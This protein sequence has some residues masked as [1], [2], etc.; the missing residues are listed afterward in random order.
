MSI[1]YVNI[2]KGGEME[3]S[4]PYHT[5]EEAILCVEALAYKLNEVGIACNKINNTTWESKRRVIRVEDNGNL[6]LYVKDLWQAISANYDEKLYLIAEVAT[7][8]ICKKVL[9]T[10]PNPFEIEKKVTDFAE[11]YYTNALERAKINW[12]IQTTYHRQ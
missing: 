5:K 7:F 11:L 2:Y 8:Y 9:P 4:T 3:T 1:A 10:Q 6:A 12:Y